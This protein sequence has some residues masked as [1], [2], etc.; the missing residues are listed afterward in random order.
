MKNTCNRKTHVIF[1]INSPCNTILKASLLH[2]GFLLEFYR[3]CVG[4]FKLIIILQ[5]IQSLLSY[6]KGNAAPAI[7]MSLV[8]PNVNFFG[9]YITL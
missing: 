5:H 6:Y 1:K 8:L 7:E 4:N 3:E 9:Y 2:K